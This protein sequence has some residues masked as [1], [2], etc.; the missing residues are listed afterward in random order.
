MKKEKRIEITCYNKV[1]TYPES[2]RK[3]LMKKYYE[4]ILCCEGSEQERYVNIYLQL[5]DGC[6]VISDEY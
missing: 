6:S 4:G 2:A 1:E 3:A 5:K